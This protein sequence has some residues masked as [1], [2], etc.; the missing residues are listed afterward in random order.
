M[1]RQGGV[2]LEGSGR[3]Q[4]TVLSNNG[5]GGGDDKSLFFILSVIE[6]S[7]EF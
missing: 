5:E 3:G 2:G 7:G 4:R 1:V 6:T